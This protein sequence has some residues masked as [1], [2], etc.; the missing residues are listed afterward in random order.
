MYSTLCAQQEKLKKCVANWITEDVDRCDGWKDPWTTDS[1]E[2]EVNRVEVGWI[3][4][5]LK[6]KSF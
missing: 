3:D 2:D 4:L 5:T 1:D 6:K